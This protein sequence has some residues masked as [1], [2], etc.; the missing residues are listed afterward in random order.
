MRKKRLKRLLALG[1]S[2]CIC[3]S[4]SVHAEE[5]NQT[6]GEWAQERDAAQDVSLEEVSE[7]KLSDLYEEIVRVED[8]PEYVPNKMERTYDGTQ[9]SVTNVLGGPTAYAA[10]DNTDP[11][12]AYLAVNGNTVQGTLTQKGEAR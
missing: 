10:D 2:L 6:K 5:A 3:F 8:A 4:T 1:L 9:Y 12:N 11:N 7:D